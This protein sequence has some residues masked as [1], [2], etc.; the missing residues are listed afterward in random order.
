MTRPEALA[1]A[2]RLFGEYARAVTRPWGRAIYDGWGN[3]RGRGLTWEAA[4]LI[5]QSSHAE[6]LGRPTGRGQ[7]TA[8][9]GVGLVLDEPHAT[10]E[11]EVYH[12]DRRAGERGGA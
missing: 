3:E 12:T 6:R 2:R 9:K 5:A 7:P 11:S 4:I 1:E 8:P 10:P